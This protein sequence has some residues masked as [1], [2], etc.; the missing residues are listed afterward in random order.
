MSQQLPRRGRI[1][2]SDY[3]FHWA[4]NTIGAYGANFNPDCHG[5]VTDGAFSADGIFLPLPS[6]DAS[7]V[8][9]AFRRMLLLRLH[10]AERLSESFMQNLLSWVHSGFSVYA[11]PVFRS[12]S[13]CFLPDSSRISQISSCPSE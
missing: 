2:A 12:N 13:S 5:L 9:E 3:E 1:L 10:K 6:L 8:M 11:G 7:A 4:V